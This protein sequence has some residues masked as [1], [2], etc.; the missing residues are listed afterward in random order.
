MEDNETLGMARPH[1]TKQSLF[2]RPL[3]V[4]FVL[5][6]TFG[7][8]YAFGNGDIK[9]NLNRVK[10]NE[11]NKA[12]PSAL[13]YDSVDQVYEALLKNYD[14]QLDNETL[15]DGIK[16]GLAHATGDPYTEYFN[17]T[18]A[19]EFD[20]SL[21]GSFTGIG[22]EL[23]K[24]NEAL[25]I[26]API[27]GFP[28]DKVG[29]RP[30]DIIVEIDG[31]KAYDLSVSDAV[32]KIRGPKDTKVTLK[33]LRGTE[34]LSF[35]ITREE[36]TIASVESKILDGNIGYLKISRFADDTSKLSREA[37]ASFKQAGIT[38]VILDM[39]SN[40]GGYLN[41]AVDLSSLWLNQ[42]DTVLE[43]RRGG[44][45]IQKLKANSTNTLKGIK[46]VVLVNEGSASASEITAG[47]LHDNNVAQLVGTKTF[48]KGSVQNLVEV[49]EGGM[50]KVTVARWYT[51]AGKNI[52]KEGIT[53]E[54]IIE[55]TDADYK[56]QKDPQLDKATELVKQ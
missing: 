30:K 8:G 7:S 25:I 3:A 17:E 33:I 49:G 34:Q 26:V 4:L 56:A 53:P 13:N 43:E 47:A 32:K 1:K 20:D 28:A 35:E 5:L 41:A 50:L 40:P 42:G 15:L 22:A 45:V 51:P 27:S 12:L 44:E 2:S 37:A 36:I 19:Q 29:L 48:G 39:R 16:N 54:T 18:G 11:Q 23:G 14:G 10:P 21:N 38:G 52:D 6:L 55:M 46:T 31:E 24:E 9:L